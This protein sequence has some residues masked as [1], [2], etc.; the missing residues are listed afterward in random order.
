MLKLHAMKEIPMQVHDDREVTH[1]SVSV[2]NV[3]GST[4]LGVCISFIK[5]VIVFLLRRLPND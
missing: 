1:V 3:M 4:S 2:W 5:I